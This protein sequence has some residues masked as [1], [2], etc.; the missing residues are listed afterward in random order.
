MRTTGISDKREGRTVHIL[1]TQTRTSLSFFNKKNG[2]E[3]RGVLGQNYY[4]RFADCRESSP[5][6][7]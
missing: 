7:S 5:G 3:V 2:N 1:I 4:V 6:L